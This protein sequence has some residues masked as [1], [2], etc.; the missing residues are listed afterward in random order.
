[1]RLDILT[2]RLLHV[3]KGADVK[4]CIRRLG[5]REGQAVILCGEKSAYMQHASQ[6]TEKNAKYYYEKLAFTDDLMSCIQDD[7]IVKIA[8]YFERHDAEQVYGQLSGLPER[9][10]ASLSGECWID[11]SN[12]T[13][14]KGNALRFIQEKCHIS[15][16]ESMAFGDYLND[17][18]LLM[19]CGESYAM[20]NAHPDLKK[21][22]KHIAP[23]NWEGGV[24]K[25]LLSVLP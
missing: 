20:E 19:S 5:E 13:A 9:V 7:Q 23:P 2:E 24:Q 12:Q 25:V 17:Y 16:E 8:V 11:L 14:N 22:A 18:E 21:I 6:E 10:R 4:E 1:M 15:R 3:I